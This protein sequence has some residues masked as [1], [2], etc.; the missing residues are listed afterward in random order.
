MARRA[1]GESDGYEEMRASIRVLESINSIDASAAWN[2]LSTFFETDGRL[3]EAIESAAQARTTSRQFGAGPWLLWQRYDQVD[4]DFLVGRWDEA[5]RAADEL[6]A[7]AESGPGHYLLHAPLSIR[8]R[9]R[10]ARGDV[11]GALDDAASALT[12]ARTI[13]DAQALVPALAVASSVFTET[14][15][16]RR[17]NELAVEFLANQRPDRITFRAPAYVA[18]S[19]QQLGALDRMLAN[20]ASA[21]RTRWLEAAERVA[22]DD[23]AAA[24]EV[25]A[26][27]ESP[28]DEAFARLRAAA[29]LVAAGRRAE[30]DAHLAR[31]LEFWRSVG[32]TRYVAEGEAL[33]AAT[34]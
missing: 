27:I 9:V 34:A 22:A 1:V 20:F 11:R 16:M 10:L 18:A 25:Y 3:R 23:W 17:G 26:V 21:R 7:E 33:L 30:A 15:D 4:T 31:A 8:A 19:M 12:H 32:A 24:A 13:G 2:N 5:V 6:I 28:T 14:G 29:Q